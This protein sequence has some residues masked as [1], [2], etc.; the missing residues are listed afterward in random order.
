MSAPQPAPV[1]LWLELSHHAA[2]RVAGWAVLR[3][4]EGQLAGTAGGGRR[5][6]AEPAALTALAA[7][8]KDVLKDVPPAAAV[9]LHTAS[10]PILAIP[11]RLAAAR[12]GEAPPTDHL[13]LWAQAATALARPGLTL[14]RVQAAPATPTAFAAAWADL[15][16]DRAKDK[17]PFTAPIPKPNLA[18]AGV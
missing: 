13:D 1:R 14:A 8:L 11:G 2:F 3:Q 9:R 10:P 12:R 6:D 18:K 5:L 15:A 7:A 4:A 16:R 17:G